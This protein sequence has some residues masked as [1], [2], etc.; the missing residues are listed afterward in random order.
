MIFKIC[1]FLLYR[2]F[3]IMDLL[4]TTPK[5]FTV[6]ALATYMHQ[7]FFLNRQ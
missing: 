2:K 1:S 6:F 4:G 7:Y 3:H 5:F